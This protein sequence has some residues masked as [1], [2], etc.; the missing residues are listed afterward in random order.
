[1]IYHDLVIIGGG[2]AGLSAAKVA[3]EAGVKS[4]IIERDF[5]VGGQLV[6]QTHMFFGSEKQYAST[7]GINI[8]NILIDDVFNKSDYIEVMTEATVVGL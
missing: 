8:A 7:R 3:A 2:P 4:L 5:K 1:M 6:K